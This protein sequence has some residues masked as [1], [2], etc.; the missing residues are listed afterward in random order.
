MSLF[1]GRYQPTSRALSYVN[2]GHLPG[3]VVRPS[4]SSPPG[5]RQPDVGAHQ[6]D[7]GARQPD[8]GGR[9]QADATGEGQ[10]PGILE[11]T[12]GGLILGVEPDVHYDEGRTELRPGDA[13]FLYTDGI[14]EARDPRGDFFGEPRLM[15]VLRGAAG[16]TAEEV[17]AA[18]QSALD[19]FR[20]DRPLDDD[21][22]MLCLTVT[23]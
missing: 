10:E 15:E 8:P 18:V 6:P 3:V 12:E 13:L 4:T 20:G 23:A 17:V 14:T 11:L 16:K 19:E 2:A 5:A 7:A 21:V 22:A 1:L 9:P